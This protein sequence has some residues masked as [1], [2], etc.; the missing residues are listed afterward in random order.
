MNAE[1]L[2]LKIKEIFGED[3]I[4]NKEF[5]EL[6]GLIKNIDDNLISW[7]IQ[8]KEGKIQPISKSILGDKIV[9]IRKIGSSERCL[10]IKIK[11]DGVK[12]V[13]LGNHKYYNEIT[14]RLGLKQSSN[15]Y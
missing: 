6:A 15:K 12:E 11:N 7:C 5:G 1:E 9:F 2:K 10:I 8:I 13:H 4:F 3:I 14:Q